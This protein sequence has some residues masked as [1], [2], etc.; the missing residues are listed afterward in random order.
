MLIFSSFVDIYCR[1]LFGEVMPM[2]SF[3]ECV[4]VSL[5][6]PG[7]W[8]KK[9]HATKYQAKLMLIEF[10]LLPVHYSWNILYTLQT[11]NMFYW[12][13]KWLVQMYFL[14]KQSLFRGHSFVFG[15]ESFCATLGEW[16]VV[17]PPPSMHFPTGCPAFLL[18]PSHLRPRRVSA[19]GEANEQ[20]SKRCL[21]VCC[22]KNMGFYYSAT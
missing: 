5:L 13:T 21:L 1:I 2:Q 16:S 8:P 7:H 10:L 15:G 6:R 20:W 3:I 9:W 17:T 19:Y 11:S 14:L 4:V 22:R 18:K 12:T